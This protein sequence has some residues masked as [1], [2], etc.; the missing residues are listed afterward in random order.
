MKEADV[1]KQSDV[2]RRNE[3]CYVCSQLVAFD[4]VTH[5]DESYAAHMT[6]SHVTHMNESCHVYRRL[7]EFDNVG[8][9][10]A[11]VEFAGS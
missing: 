1:M 4:N 7:V 9:F 3:S 5:I 8:L 2:A 6:E 10:L 11:V